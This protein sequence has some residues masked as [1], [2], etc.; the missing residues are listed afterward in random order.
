MSIHS[1]LLLVFIQVADCGSFSAAARQLNLPPKT[2]SKQMA[3]LESLLGTSLFARSTRQ[4][5]L[6]PEGHAAL[7]HARTAVAA[8]AHIREATRREPLSG[9]IR[10]TAPA[11]FGRKYIAPAIADFVRAYPRIGFDLRLSD[12]VADLYGGQFDLAVRIGDLP[13][14]TLVARRLAHNRRILTASPEYLRRHGTPQTPAELAQHHCLI[15]A[16]PGKRCD[17]WALQN[18]QGE[19][20][21]IQVTG[22]LQSDSGEALHAW[23]VAGLGISLRETWDVCDA[24]AQGQLLRVLPE[25]ERTPDKISLVYPR[26]STLPER[27]R[28]FMDFLCERWQD[29]PWDKG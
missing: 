6:T 1:E 29:E 9:C 15:F 24:L 21:R 23:C 2:V 4:L 25:W 10:L 14:S 22:Q 5:H 12:Q 11:P 20:A 18:A 8:I 26:Q 3:R 13:D 16:H 27:L 17:E 7:A 28:V 19:T